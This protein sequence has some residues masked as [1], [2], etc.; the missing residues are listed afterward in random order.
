M[1]DTTSQIY[2]EIRDDQKNGSL[3][4]GAVNRLFGDHQ[5]NLC[6]TQAMPSYAELARQ[7]CLFVAQDPT[8]RPAVAAMPTTTAISTL[9]NGNSELSGKCLIL[10]AVSYIVT[11]NTA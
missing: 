9:Y 4:G 6:V 2:A 5:G 7:G 11:A 3:P 8:T 1:A 10:F